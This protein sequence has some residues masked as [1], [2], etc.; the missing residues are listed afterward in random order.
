MPHQTLIVLKSWR[1]PKDPSSG[2]FTYGVERNEH[3]QSIIRKKGVPTFRNDPWNTINDLEGS[4][5]FN[6]RDIQR[7]RDQRGGYICVQYRE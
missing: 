6:V 3:A 1:G 5:K 2:K 4:G 7:Y